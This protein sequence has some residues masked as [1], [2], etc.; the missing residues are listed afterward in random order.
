MFTIRPQQL[1]SLDGEALRAFEQLTTPRVQAEF[2]ALC[3]AMGAEVLRAAIEFGAVRAA[4]HDLEDHDDLGLYVDLMLRL[5]SHFDTDPQLPWAGHGFADDTEPNPGQR[6]RTVEASAKEHLEIVGGPGWQLSSA[7]W[8]R[9]AERAW[10]QWEVP[11]GYGFEA[12]VEATLREINP[13]K[14]RNLEGWGRVRR[15]IEGGRVAAAEHGLAED[16]GT[17]LFIALRFAL[18]TGVDRDPQFPWVARSLAPS[19]EAEPAS[20]AQALLDETNAFFERLR[21]STSE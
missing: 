18:G 19:T 14:V 16:W 20:P 12:A 1:R 9:M 4:S 8:Q 2:G 10:Q 7:V 13:A 11:A 15:L 6:L 5:G 21:A 3:D 17:M